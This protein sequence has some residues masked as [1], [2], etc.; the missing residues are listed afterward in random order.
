MLPHQDRAVED[1]VTRD[2][3][4]VRY[5]TGTGK[6]RIIVEACRV[7]M[8]AGDIPGLVLVPNSLLEQSWQQFVEW[9]G[10]AWTRKNVESLDGGMNLYA[11]REQLK[12]GR[13]NI[14]LL[15]H[16]AL[17]YPIIR[18]GVTS[19]T[20]GFVMLDEASRFRNPS[21]RTRSLR[22]AG[23]KAGSRYAFTGNLV[24]KSPLDAYYVL[25]W[26][27]PGVWGTRNRDAFK[28]NYCL[29]GGFGGTQA[30]GLRPDKAK[31]FKAILDRKQSPA[32]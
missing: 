17:S 4:L 26:L 9:A 1:I 15:S 13:A 16:E 6:M 22:A 25:D 7:M 2:D 10:D 3:V 19:R 24:V 28:T 8:A 23:V 5:G 12:R 29:L 27:Q 21:K 20:W 11:R 31:E 32:N 14:F 30:L 18:E